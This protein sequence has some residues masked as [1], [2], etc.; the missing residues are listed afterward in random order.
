M[1]I[2][3]ALIAATTAAAA[4]FWSYPRDLALVETNTRY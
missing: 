1:P 2:G 4:C 3:A